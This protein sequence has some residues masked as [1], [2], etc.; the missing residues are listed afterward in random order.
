MIGGPNKKHIAGILAPKSVFLMK[1]GSPVHRLYMDIKISSINYIIVVKTSLPCLL[2]TR[3]CCVSQARL[4]FPYPRMTGYMI[5]VS[6]ILTT[7]VPLV[8]TDVV[9][10]YT[11]YVSEDNKEPFM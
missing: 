8:Q 6:L 5:V 2:I 11:Y 10:R 3:A 4:Y 1:T 9:E 7:V